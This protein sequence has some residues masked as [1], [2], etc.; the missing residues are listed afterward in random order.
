M[1]AVC[2]VADPVTFLPWIRDPGW[3][4]SL[5]PDPDEQ[6]ESYFSEL[7]NNF[8]GV[9]ILYFF[10]EDSGSDMEKIL[11]RDKHPGSATLPVTNPDPDV[12]KCRTVYQRHYD[13]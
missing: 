5:D 1:I 9:K 7:K 13:R 10:D 3:V 8:F 2:S 4:K 6:P 12:L 11:I